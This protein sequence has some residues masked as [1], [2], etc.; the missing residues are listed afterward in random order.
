MV[1]NLQEESNDDIQGQVGGGLLKG[2]DLTPLTILAGLTL[3][4]GGKIFDFIQNVWNPTVNVL[5]AKSRVEPFAPELPRFFV[6]G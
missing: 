6:K 3:K 1:L 5:D 2:K 4:Y